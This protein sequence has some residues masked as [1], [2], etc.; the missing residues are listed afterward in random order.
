MR[1]IAVK[2]TISKIIEDNNDKEEYSIGNC[3]RIDSEN[4]ANII[5]N[6]MISND[7]ILIDVRINDRKSIGYRYPKNA[8]PF[9]ITKLQ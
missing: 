2:E 7:Y 9:D 6:K 4:E 5:I 3:V 8:I 1:F